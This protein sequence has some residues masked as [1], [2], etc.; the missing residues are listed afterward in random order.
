MGP[1]D[2][3]MNHSL[4]DRAERR[5]LLLYLHRNNTPS[6][7]LFCKNVLC[8]SEIINYIESNYLVWAWDCTRDANYQR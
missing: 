6:T 7:H 2:E 4:F 1:L 5:P 8:N 3:A